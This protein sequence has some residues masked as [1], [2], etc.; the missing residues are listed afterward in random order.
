MAHA[1]FRESPD[2][3]PQEFLM[4]MVVYTVEPYHRNGCKESDKTFDISDFLVAKD[5]A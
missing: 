4:D 5:E 3:W 1:Y 2:T